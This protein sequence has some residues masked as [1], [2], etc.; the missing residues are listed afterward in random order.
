MLGALWPLLLGLLIAGVPVLM[1]LAPGLFGIDTSD[2]S[3]GAAL[4]FLLFFTV[5]AAVLVTVVGYFVKWL[6][7]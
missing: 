6:A 5:P 4:P 2:P 7:R 1:A 3:A